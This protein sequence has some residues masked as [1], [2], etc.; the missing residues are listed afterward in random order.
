[1]TLPGFPEAVLGDSISNK[2][3]RSHDALLPYFVT[4]HHHW[5]QLFINPLFRGMLSGGKADEQG[6]L[7]QVESD[8]QGE[9]TPALSSAS[10]T[11]LPE[12]PVGVG[13]RVELER[14][15]K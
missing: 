10:L 3:A 13:A 12:A 2:N 7:R 15:D 4:V 6:K 11:L 5:H 14:N 1:M 9:L 8:H